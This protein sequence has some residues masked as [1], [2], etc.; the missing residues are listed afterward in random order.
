MKGEGREEG[1]NREDGRE[2]G[3]EEG[4]VVRVGTRKQ[5]GRRGMKEGGVKRLGDG[6]RGG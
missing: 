2:G 3:M 4:R 1:W 6:W 5:G